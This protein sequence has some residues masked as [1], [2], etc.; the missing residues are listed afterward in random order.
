MSVHCSKLVTLVLLVV[1]L[2]A[3]AC[4]PAPLA[5]PTATSTPVPSVT[6]T[7]SATATPP[8]S[9]TPIVT[10]S[11]TPTIRPTRTKGPTYTPRVPTDTPEPAAPVIDK[12]EFPAEIKCDGETQYVLYVNFHD[13]NGDAYRFDLKLIQSRRP[14]YLQTTPGSFDVPAKLQQVGMRFPYGVTWSLPGDIVKIRVAITDHAG[15]TGWDFFEFKC[16]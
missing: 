13:V 4:G 3:S 11:P 6:P 5:A 2:L 14:G 8:P 9:A 15:L 7:A 1:S 12:L 10:A 16:K